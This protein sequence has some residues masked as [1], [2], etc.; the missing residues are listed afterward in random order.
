MRKKKGKG[1]TILLVVVLL[2]GL[3]VMLYPVISDWWNSHT[4]SRAI[5]TYQ[6]QASQLKEVDIEAILKRAR[7]YNEGIRNLR[8][9]FLDYD[10]VKDYDKILDITGTGIMGYVSI[11]QIRVELPIKYC[12]R[13]PSRLNSSDRRRGKSRSY[14]RT[15]RTSVSK[16]V[17][18]SG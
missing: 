7:E 6:K 4:Q 18:R 15:Q 11:P 1:S 16:A 9:P 12:G 5:A 8:E 13:S 14:F 17:Y 10:E 3:S 2:V